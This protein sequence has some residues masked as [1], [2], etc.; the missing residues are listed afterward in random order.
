MR[1]T[2]VRTACTVSRL[3]EANSLPT[4]QPHRQLV[5]VWVIKGAYAMPT[6]DS[7]VSCG[8]VRPVQATEGEYAYIGWR[9]MAPPPVCRGSRN[10]GLPEGA[11]PP[12]GR[13]AGD[14]AL[15]AKRERR[16]NT[17]MALPPPAGSTKSWQTAG[18]GPVA[19]GRQQQQLTYSSNGTTVHELH[20]RTPKN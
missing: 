15:P 16:G 8:W 10:T 11:G 20:E 5:Y 4:L 6:R 17:V 1:R 9:L 18:A 3:E 7:M 2:G 19:D 12:R 14:R 13:S